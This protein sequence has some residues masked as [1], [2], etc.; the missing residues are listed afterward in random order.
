MSK[1]AAII[2]ERLRI[3]PYSEEFLTERYIGWLND[4]DVMRYSEGRF[5]K[6]TAASCKKYI[7]SSEN[8]P[9]YLW[10]VVENNP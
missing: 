7:K 5:G 6:H 2:T 3:I 10:A 9:N 1:S 8:S 4:P